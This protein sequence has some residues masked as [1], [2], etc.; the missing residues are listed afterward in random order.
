MTDDIVI[1]QAQ[2]QLQKCALHL[3][4]IADRVAQAKTVK[5]FSHDRSKRALALSVTEKL[6]LGDSAAAS[7]FRGRASN[8]YGSRL[9]ELESQYEDALKVIEQQDALRCKFESARSILSV[10]KAKIG[11]L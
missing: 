9:A 2:A 10:E 4:Q 6:L 11:L 3:E 7:E 1:T 5:E 8:E